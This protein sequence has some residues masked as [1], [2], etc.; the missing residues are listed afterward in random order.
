[1]FWPIHSPPSTRII[2]STRVRIEEGMGTALARDSFQGMAGINVNH[3]LIIKSAGSFA[4]GLDVEG[5]LAF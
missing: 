3:K 1:M 4:E 5:G 2:P